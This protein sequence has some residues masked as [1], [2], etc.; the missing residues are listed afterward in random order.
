MNNEQTHYNSAAAHAYLRYESD[1]HSKKQRI[2]GGR[3]IASSV[4]QPRVILI[5][6]QV[7]V[8]THFDLFLSFLCLWSAVGDRGKTG[9]LSVGQSIACVSQ[10]Q[11]ASVDQGQEG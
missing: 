7:L 4:I 11:G 2:C 6:G 8:G 3:V 5:I 10:D 1:K 9:V